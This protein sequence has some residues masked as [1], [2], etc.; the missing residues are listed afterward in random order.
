[1]VPDPLAAGV[2]GPALFGL[3]AAVALLAYLALLASGFA[4]QRAD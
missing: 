3:V 2:A 4:A 1:M